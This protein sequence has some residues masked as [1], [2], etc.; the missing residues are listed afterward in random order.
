MRLK[1]GKAFSHI[2][3][4]SAGWLTGVEGLCPRE[5][6]SRVPV[7]SN[8]S[9][10]GIVRNTELGT[11]REPVRRTQKIWKAFRDACQVRRRQGVGGNGRTAS[12]HGR[13]QGWVRTRTARASTLTYGS[14]SDPH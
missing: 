9:R 14:N 6:T 13:A 2:K 8:S 1:N 12:S 7:K 4:Q 10:S 3:G 5:A 11:V